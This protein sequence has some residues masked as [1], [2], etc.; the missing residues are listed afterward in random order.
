M[1]FL[2]ELDVCCDWCED[3]RAQ[4]ELVNAQN[5]VVGRYCRACGRKKLKE[6]QEREPR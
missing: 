2:R 1:A 3:H 4:V 6:I 5:A